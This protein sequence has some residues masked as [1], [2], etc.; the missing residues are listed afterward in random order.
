MR[1]VP[2]IRTTLYLPVELHADLGALSHKLVRT[3]TALVVEALEAHLA[4]ELA[5]VRRDPRRAASV[6]ARLREWAE[7][8]YGRRSET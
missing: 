4:F 2:S 3:M 7:R 6:A 8:A 1:N 5:E